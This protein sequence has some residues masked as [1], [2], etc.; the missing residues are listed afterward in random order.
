[1]SNS[2]TVPKI[3]LQ[4]VAVD[5]IDTRLPR[6]H[7]AFAPHRFKYNSKLD[8][9]VQTSRGSL[10]KMQTEKINLQ[11]QTP[12]S[13]KPVKMLG[14]PEIILS[15]R[16]WD[17]VFPDAMGRL[18]ANHEEPK[19]RRETAYSIRGLKDWDQV[20]Q[21]LE[22]CRRDYLDDKG[23]TKKVKRQWREFSENIG[24][25]Q[26]A[27]NLVPD[28]DYITPIRGTV[29]FL[30][31]AIKRASETRQQVLQGL[32]KLDS[33]F[34]DIELF[35]MVFPTDEGVFEAGTELVVSALAAVEKLIGFYIKSRGRK[36]FSSMFKGEDYEKDVI[37]SLDDITT[38]SEA[39]R[40]EATKAD[41][42]QSAKNWRM[43]EQRHEELRRTLND[44]QMEMLQRQASLKSHFEATGDKVNDIY[45]LLREYEKNQEQVRER[46]I[47]LEKR[48]EELERDISD[49]KHTT[50][51]PQSA[52]TP[53]IIS[54]SSTS[55]SMTPDDLW[56]IFRSFSFEDEDMKHTMEKQER[57]P[58]HERAMSENLL[59]SSRFRNWMV[60]PASRELLVQ[61]E[62]AGDRQISALSVFAATLTTALRGRPKYVSLIHFCG[63]HTDLDDDV[64]AGPRGMIMSFIAQLLWQ[65]D[66]DTSF[67]HDYVDLSWDEY[68]EDPSLED[69]CDLLT[70]LV[71]QLPPGQTVFYV[72][73]GVY[74]YERDAYVE[75]LIDAMGC[76][77]DTTLDEKVDA[78]VKILVTSPCRTVETREAFHDN[79]MLLLTEQSSATLDA[80]PRRF[81]HQVSRVLETEG[82]D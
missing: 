27:W 77:L 30:F 18:G 64:D 38:K 48:N 54:S 75:V 43:A 58:S 69:L 19:G 70:W 41:M 3:H 49:L 22:D 36:A 81:Q 47:A 12:V 66:F 16:F 11:A 44:G 21:K 57:L 52:F 35:L 45:N 40:Y 28:I 32:D 60:S 72:I 24:P 71:R 10:V 13:T 79:A 78:T 5:F 20:Y 26:E 59:S 50:H 80:S 17:R 74:H 82:E 34:R 37:S 65:W 8:C 46:Y 1:M 9:Y 6:I 67:L 51:K 14:P 31:E 76:F 68:G 61:G 62:F 39:L 73:D 42:S 7:R 33:M 23:W 15:M 25:V 63:L 56:D 2:E 29:D 4:P 55:G 53:K